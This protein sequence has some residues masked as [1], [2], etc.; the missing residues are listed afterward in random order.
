MEGSHISLS[1]VGAFMAG[2]LYRDASAGI[3]QGYRKLYSFYIDT[4]TLVGVERA[5]V[6]TGLAVH[7]NTY[8]TA[9]GSTT[10]EK[11]GQL[12][13]VAAPKES[14]AV[15]MQPAMKREHRQN[16]KGGQTNSPKG[17]GGQARCERSWQS[18][19]GFTTILMGIPQW[20]KNTRIL[21]SQT[22]FLAGKNSPPVCWH[23]A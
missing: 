11:Q 19:T 12:W 20:R 6:C 13:G 17:G 21:C 14:V 9:T 4:T 15:L 5:G 1:M 3:G 10:R 23:L 16:A 8:S 22:K 7:L 18:L 2:D